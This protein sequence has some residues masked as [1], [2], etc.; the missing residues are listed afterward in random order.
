MTNDITFEIIESIGVID[1]NERGWTK[2]INL[3]SW[4][5][6]KPKFDIRDW[7]P[8]H[9]KMGKG[10]TLTEWQMNKVIQLLEERNGF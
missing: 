1:E 4:N 3:V 2:E 9:D 5:G 8:E 7:S 10:I 6:S